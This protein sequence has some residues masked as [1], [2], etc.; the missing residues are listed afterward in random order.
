VNLPEAASD[1]S[2]RRHYLYLNDRAAI[3]PNM[4]NE[5][6]VRAT[7]SDSITRSVLQGQPRI[8]VLDAFVGGSGQTNYNDLHNYLQLNETLS[9]SH[10]KHLIKAGGNLPELGRYSLNDRSNFDGTFQFSSLQ[11][12]V[13]G[14]PF[15][16]VYQQGTSQLVYWQKELGLFVQ[17]EMRVRPGLSIALGLRYDWQNYISN[18][19]NFAPRLSF[20]FA[21]GKSRK[22]VFRGGAGIFYETTGQAA[23]AD[24]L[25]F[26]GQTLQQI[27]L[28]NPTY[29]NPFTAGGV[30]SD[31]SKEH[32]PLCTRS[33]F[34]HTT[35]STALVWKRS[36][37]NRRHSRPRTSGCADSICFG[38]ATSML[39]FLLSMFSALIPRSA[40]FGRSN[41]RGT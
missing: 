36:Y 9:W 26:N 30:G 17:D 28:S 24:V 7:T 5:F 25:R 14:K 1:E 16:F 19:Q 2:S 6:S 37:K 29:P 12:Y 3:T 15:S 23:I 22:V 32:C 27:V 8:V 35:S 10:G 21:P 18:P 31:P 38:R 41:R 39:P 4:L 34:C 20:A 40:L 33:S 13:Q 11:D